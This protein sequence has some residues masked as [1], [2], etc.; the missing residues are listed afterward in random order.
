MGRGL[1]P[2]DIVRLRT[3]SSCWNVLGKY[4]PYS[5]LFYF[6]IKRERVALTIVVPFKPVVPAETLK[7]CALVGLHI[8]V[9]RR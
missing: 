3:S 4:G 1:D 9:S 2:W 8:F 7:A 6:F 5:E